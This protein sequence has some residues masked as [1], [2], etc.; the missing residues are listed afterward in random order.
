MAVSA[1]SSLDQ[2]EE[3]YTQ[4]AVLSPVQENNEMFWVGTSLSIA[5]VPLLIGE[6]ELEE[7]I[8][9][10]AYTAIPGTKS[11]VLGVA[12]HRGGL[13]PI[14]SGDV[15]FRNTPYSSKPREYCMVVRL[16]G[17]HFGVTLSRIERDLKFPV[18]ERDMTQTIDSDFAPYCLGGFH[19][20][21]DFLAILDIPKLVA[22][23]GLA[24][25]S[26]TVKVSIE[27]KNND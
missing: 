2:L 1:L 21:S 6:G 19:R 17:Y 22:D 4:G 5:G 12:S 3:S 9:T 8:E 25:A 26:A 15:L 7:I 23:S 24:N 10:P 14:I 18:T 13:L 16:P 20:N 27:D 11:W